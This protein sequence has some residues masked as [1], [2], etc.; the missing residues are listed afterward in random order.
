M[1]KP[2]IGFNEQMIMDYFSMQPSDVKGT[3]NAGTRYYERILLNKIFS[4]Y[5]FNIPDK[6]MLA[7]FRFFLFCYGSIA[8]IY[9]ETLGWI[10][11]P[12]SIEE[13]NYLY[14]PSK[15]EV[16]ISN[17][18]EKIIEGEIGKNAE[19]VYLVDDR[20]GIMDIVKR[21]AVMLA[22]CDKAV[23]VNLMNANVAYVA[24]AEDQ[25]QAMEIKEGYGKATTG[26]PLVVFNDYLMF[27]ES[28]KPFFKDV[29]G[30][31]IA[32]D[33]ITARRSIMNAFLTEIGIRNS[34]YDK[35]ERLTT[36]EIA[37]NNDETRSLVSVWFENLNYCFEKC[38]KLSGETLEVSLNYD[39]MKE[40][41]ELPE[42][43]MEV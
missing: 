36:D 22:N 20:F 41:A 9:D 14:R 5:D 2:P 21:Y 19:I 25:K 30:S 6:D 29:K 39:Y 3:D 1:L 35:R 42:E 43:D 34:N 24:Y 33:V 4:V 16:A 31:F 17:G 28:M 32:N 7:W 12:Y 15:I 13:L 27:D 37:E 18:E 11:Y 38:S 40:A 8:Y 23:N 10:F 26:E